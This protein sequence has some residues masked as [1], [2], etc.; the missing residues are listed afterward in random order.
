ME[1][2]RPHFPIYQYGKSTFDQRSDKLS[3]PRPRQTSQLLAGPFVQLVLTRARDALAL[4]CLASERG[5]HS[6]L[7]V[8]RYHGAEG[9]T[10]K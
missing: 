9:S 2:C 10:G 3:H 6:L 4:S 5:E 7:V 1:S 8:L